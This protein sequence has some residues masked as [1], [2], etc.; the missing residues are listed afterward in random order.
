MAV[1]TDVITSGV[2]TTFVCL[3]EDPHAL[4]RT[5][6]ELFNKIVQVYPQAV[7]SV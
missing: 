2:I 6:P 1:V 7:L 4:Q 3:A 5:K